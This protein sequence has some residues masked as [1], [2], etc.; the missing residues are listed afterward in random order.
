MMGANSNPACVAAWNAHGMSYSRWLSYTTMVVDY[1]GSLQPRVPILIAVNKLGVWDQDDLGFARALSAEA[2][3]FGFFVGNAGFNGHD[4]NW[5]AIY[6]AHRPLTYMQIANPQINSGMFVPFLQSAAPLGIELY[7]LYA[8]DYKAAYVD[9]DASIRAALEA[10][11]T[12]SPCKINA[13]GE[14]RQDEQRRSGASP[15]DCPPRRRAWR[16]RPQS[17]PRSTARIGAHRQ[18]LARPLD[19]RSPIGR[20]HRPGL[21]AKKSRSTVSWPILG[22]SPR[23]SLGAKLGRLT[24]ALLLAI[25]RTARPA[26]EQTRD[27]VENLRLPGINLVRMHPVPLRRI[28]NCRILAQRLQCNLRL[29][30]RIKLLA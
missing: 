13:I 1:I 25:A 5:N 21:L 17:A 9:G 20:A 15:P 7:E 22:S 8:R 10:V 4:A 30:R 24:L 12:P 18:V 19:H 6:Q 2:A 3:K 23:T 28:R 11:G 29:E 14:H 26:R 27:I 16:G